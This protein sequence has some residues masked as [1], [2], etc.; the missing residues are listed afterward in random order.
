MCMSLMSPL[1]LGS[2]FHMGYCGIQLWL[3][4]VLWGLRSRESQKAMSSNAHFSM[5]YIRGIVWIMKSLL[6][7]KILLDDIYFWQVTILLPSTED[8]ET[9]GKIRKALTDY[10]RSHVLFCSVRPTILQIE[11]GKDAEMTSFFK[12][13]AEDY[14]LKFFLDGICIDT[15]PGAILGLRL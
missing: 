13:V 2:Q 1:Y 12:K 9:L 14:D 8:T 7:E 10:A 4:Q 3:N 11:A 6:A 5:V 15:R